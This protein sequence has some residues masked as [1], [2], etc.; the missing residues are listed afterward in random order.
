MLDCICLSLEMDPDMA[1]ADDVES[2]ASAPSKRPMPVDSG[3]VTMS[4]GGGA[5]EA[6]LH[7]MDAWYIDFI[8]ANLNTP[9]PAP[10]PIP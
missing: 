4:Q 1:T 2:N 7:M 3:P 5:G 10:P 6:Y 9:F 8:C